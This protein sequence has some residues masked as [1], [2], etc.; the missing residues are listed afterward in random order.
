M[1]LKPV[2]I[3]DLDYIIYLENHPENRSYIGQWSKATHLKALGDPDYQYLLFVQGGKNL[4]YALMLGLENP[5][6]S[7]NLK[8]FVVEEKGRG[9]GTK[10]LELVIQFSFERLKAHRL[11][12]DVRA[13]NRRADQ[14]YQ[15]LGFR[16]EGTLKKASKYEGGYS[17][18]KLYA[19]LRE[20][21]LK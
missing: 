4:G 20:E 8:R 12:L 3:T 19:M 18:L 2:E 11:W 13:F 14:L 6:D 7:V 1:Q 21:Y 16:H 9:F 10:A 5:D 15:K 17:D